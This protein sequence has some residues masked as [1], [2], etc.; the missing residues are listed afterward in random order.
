MPFVRRMERGA[1]VCVT[2]ACHA[3]VLSFVFLPSEL[4]L[5][6]VAAP[7]EVAPSELRPSWVAAPSEVAPVELWPWGISVV[8]GLPY[9][10]RF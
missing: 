7:S 1:N 3:V 9:L 8:Q 2:L 10:N 4:R 5:L 6:W